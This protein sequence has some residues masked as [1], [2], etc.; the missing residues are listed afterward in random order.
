[1]NITKGRVQ[2]RTLDKAAQIE[3]M[4]NVKMILISRSQNNKT[5][6]KVKKTE[7]NET[8]RLAPLE[9]RWSNGINKYPFSTVFPHL[10]H[11]ISL[12]KPNTLCNKILGL[13]LSL[14]THGHLNQAGYNLLVSLVATYTMP[15][16]T[17]GPL[18]YV[19]LS[20]ANTRPHYF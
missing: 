9:S 20:M 10:L 19:S 2:L 3:Q 8:K 4:S 16:Q 13:S 14:Y 7:L 12:Q 5:W 17:H 6:R 1:M 18:L 15:S 11:L